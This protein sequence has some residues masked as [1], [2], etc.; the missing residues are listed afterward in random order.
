MLAILMRISFRTK[1]S[2]K[3]PERAVGEVLC[4][5][6]VETTNLL[7]EVKAELAAA[8]AQVSQLAEQAYP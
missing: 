4:V 5:A 2:S 7:D 8:P 6:G 3:A 1:K